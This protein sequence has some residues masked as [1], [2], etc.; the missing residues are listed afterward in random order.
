M[1][2]MTNQHAS[3]QDNI[4]IGRWGV[5]TAFLSV[6]VLSMP[7]ALSGGSYQ[8]IQRDGAIVVIQGGQQE[9]H[10]ISYR[11]AW[12]MPRPVSVGEVNDAIRW[13]AG[14]YRLSPALLRAVIQ[15]ESDFDATAISPAGA[16]GLMQLMPGTAASLRVRDPFNPVEN[17]RGGAKHLRYLLDRFHGDI[18]LAIAAYNAGEYRVKRYRRVPPIHETQVYVR[19]VL[20]YYHQFRRHPR[21]L[22]SPS[23]AL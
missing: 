6:V 7:A 15:A 11:P 8:A 22:A 21:S 4:P 9:T 12:T 18:T 20:T 14:R 1:E 19:K 2:T 13:Y 5:G 17:I 23:A 16:L 10:P 3:Q